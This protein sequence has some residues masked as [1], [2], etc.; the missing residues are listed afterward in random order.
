M[1]PLCDFKAQILHDRFAH[2]SCGHIMSAS[3]INTVIVTGNKHVKFD[4][5]FENL[6]KVVVLRA[7]LDALVGFA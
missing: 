3:S 1:S 4:F 6:G 5:S 2:F 7:L